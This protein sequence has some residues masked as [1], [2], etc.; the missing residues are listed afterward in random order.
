[1]SIEWEFV[2]GVTGI[3]SAII[4]VLSFAQ[5]ARVKPFN[6]LSSIKP[7]KFFHYILASSC[8]A[9]LVLIGHWIFD[10]LGPIVTREEELKIFAVA[11]SF[12]TLVGFIYALKG[13]G[14]M[15]DT[16]KPEPSD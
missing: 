13:M 8:W 11:L 4:A 9:L 7:N 15:K 6:K 16:N 12:P 1:M 10:P 2:N 5:I 14:L 3:V